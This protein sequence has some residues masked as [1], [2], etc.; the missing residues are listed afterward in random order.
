MKKI[1][2]WGLFIFLIMIFV[3]GCKGADKALPGGNG[4]EQKP[5]TQ[6]SGIPKDNGEQ[7]EP[8][9]VTYVPVYNIPSDD[10]PLNVRTTELPDL[11]AAGELYE[12]FLPQIESNKREIS[13]QKSAPCIYITTEEKRSI[14][15]KEEYTASV[16][17]VFNCAAQYELSA[18][19]GVKVRGNSTADQG[20]EKP[21]RIK[22][23]KKQGMLGLHGG[24]A[25]KSWVLMRSYWNL[26]PDYMGF[27][28]AKTVFGGKYYSSDSCYVNLYING[29]YKGIY[30]LCEQNQAAK[31]RVE[32]KEPQEG[33]FSTDIG[34]FLE[35]DNYAGDEHPYFSLD[36]KQVEM[37]DIS[38]NK[39][40]TF[41]RNYSVKSDIN[42]AGQLEFI[43]RYLKGCFEIL[44]EAAQ[45]DVPLMF[46]NELNTVSAEGIYT[47]QEAV[48][49]VID[50]ESLADMLII[51]ELVHNYDVGAGSFF[52]AVDFS[53]E[54]MYRRLTFL[55]P[56]DFNWA[57][58]E[59]GN[60]Y[61]A[62]TF[63]KIMDDGYDRS[64]IWFIV[65]MKAEWFRDAVKEKWMSLRETKALEKTADM[66]VTECEKLSGDLGDE[67]WK[68]EMVKNIRTFVLDRIKWLDSEWER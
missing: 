11:S 45:N 10:T 3:C 55:A 29:D 34:Y 67:A 58:Y 19:A 63:Q 2:L 60:E 23:E 21:Y 62:A 31:G 6:T 48:C 15:S 35:M 16:V 20:D 5:D 9:A 37:V 12:A 28:L 36:H 39:R 4:T 40:K 44:Y 52:M 1:L 22:F 30:L 54:S 32:V 42:T 59:S 41:S 17:D 68:I 33:D 27:E 65:A 64:N 57:Y 49:A 26:A 66:V 43:E 61:F 46:D 50:I 8:A 47:P 24:R 56:W 7:T 25:F 38:G 53:E 51:E 13:S 14:L 18:P